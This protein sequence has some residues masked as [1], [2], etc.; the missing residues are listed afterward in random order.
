LLDTYSRTEQEAIA[1]H[2]LVRLRTGHLFFTELA[3]RF[4]QA[5]SR[6]APKVGEEDDIQAVA[7]TRYPPGLARALKQ[8]GPV[9]GTSA[10]LWFAA[11]SSS[12]RPV[13]ARIDALEDL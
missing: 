13:A 9:Q 6:F 3:A 8:A 12:H 10:C 11:H 1:A 4:G 7:I 5:T 2:C